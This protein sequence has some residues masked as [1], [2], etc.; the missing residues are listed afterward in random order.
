[1]Y[2]RILLKLSGEALA[3]NNNII[4]QDILDKTVK[5]INS[6]LEKNIEL[7][8]VIGGGNIFRGES[9]SKTGANKITGDHMGMMATIINGLAINDACHRHNIQSSIMSAVDIGSGICDSFDFKKAKNK[10]ANKEVLIFVGGTGNPRFTTDSA[11]SLR[12]IEIEA[13]IIFKATGVDGVYSSDPKKNPNATKYEK[14]SFDEAINKKLAV[15]DVSA[16]VMCR[17]NNIDICVFSMLEDS[18]TLSRILSGEQL[19]TIVSKQG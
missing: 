6:V 19:G 7:A 3:N 15:M 14:L 4:D 9:F 5:I 10:L 8:I 17:D 2:K 1:M 12:A 13:D 11:A 18:N 16:F